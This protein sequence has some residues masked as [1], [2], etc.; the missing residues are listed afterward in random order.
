MQ[1][2]SREQAWN[3]R[4]M[5]LTSLLAPTLLFALAVPHAHAGTLRG[6][7]S[8]IDGDTVRVQ[9]KSI[10]L[11]G[12]DAPE[13]DQLCTRPDDTKWRCG[14]QSALALDDLIARRPVECQQ[15][16][17]DQYGR[18]VAECFVGAV[19]LNRWMVRNGWAIAYRSFSTEYVPDERQ[20][21]AE[22]LNMWS[23]SF[24]SPA[25]HR[26]QGRPARS[27][28][29]ASASSPPS[30]DCTLKGN[31]D[32]KGERIFHSPG[33]RDYEKTSI[34][35]GAGERWF[36]TTEQATAAGWRPAQR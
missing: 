28:R 12:M 18:V 31:I 1:A 16:D 25:Q 29:S 34:N 27:S 30:A 11:H 6:V 9:G 35:T 32:A 17:I 3:H 15:R 23:G 22:R 36:C 2:R 20:A 5:R 24:D 19:S 13:S 21:Q 4:R 8:V 7:A 26:R 10:R 33:Q 14:Q